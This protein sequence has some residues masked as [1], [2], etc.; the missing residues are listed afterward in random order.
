MCSRLECPSPC[1]LFHR[2]P[3]P[4][5][6]TF[7]PSTTSIFSLFP[8]CGKDIQQLPYTQAVVH[9]GHSKACPQKLAVHKTGP[10]PGRE[11]VEMRDAQSTVHQSFSKVSCLPCHAGCLRS[12]LSI[13]LLV[14]TPSRV[15]V[16]KT[17]QN[18]DGRCVKCSAVH[19]K[20]QKRGRGGGAGGRF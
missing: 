11:V 7:C 5:C 1:N 3:Y 9:H 17:A 18:V 8:I 2:K 4:W 10:K 16:T 13:S 19:K 15:P 20:D 6:A 12:C 14:V